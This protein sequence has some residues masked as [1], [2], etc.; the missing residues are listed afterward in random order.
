MPKRHVYAVRQPCG[1]PLC[2]ATAASAAAAAACAVVGTIDAI[3]A[4][5]QER[6]IVVQLRTEDV[7]HSVETFLGLNVTRT[8]LIHT[9]ALEY[10]CIMDVL[11]ARCNDLGIGQRKG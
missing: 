7:A 3:Q 10:E 4:D 1:I 6:Y 8:P 9:G 2:F 11:G 5:R